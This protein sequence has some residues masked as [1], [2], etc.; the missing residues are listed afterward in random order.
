M[1]KKTVKVWAIYYRTRVNS[2]SKWEK[3]WVGPLGPYAFNFLPREVKGYCGNRS[4]VFRIRKQARDVANAK[5]LESNKTWTWVQYQV[6]P[7]NLT[8]EEIK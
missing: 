3:D 1:R 2:T 8:Y 6:R 7:I 5:S 4:F